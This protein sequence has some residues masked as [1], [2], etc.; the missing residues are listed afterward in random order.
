MLGVTNAFKVL[1]LIDVTE[2]MGLDV[3]SA[4]VAVA[5]ATEAL[6]KGLISERETLVPLKFGEPE[7]YKQALAIWG[8]EKTT[9]YVCWAREL[10]KLRSNTAERILPAFWDRRWEAMRRE[11]SFLRPRPWGFA[12]PSGRR[13]ILLRPEAPGQ[14]CGKGGELSGSG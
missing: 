13:G 9:F 2:K 4:G 6:E 8:K 7:M 12:I 10:S 14:R 5:W 1:S 11:R 3:M